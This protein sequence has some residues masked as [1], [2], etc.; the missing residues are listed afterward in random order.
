MRALA[1]CGCVILLAATMAA[2]SFTLYWSS[3]EQVNPDGSLSV[4]PTAEVSG[5]DD[6]SF[7]FNCTDSSNIATDRPALML[8]G[9]PWFTHW[10]VSGGWWIDF[11][12]T[13]PAVLISPGQQA[14]LSYGASVDAACWYD[15]PE[16]PPSFDSWYSLEFQNGTG[17]PCFI[18]VNC[19]EPLPPVE[20]G[21]PYTATATVF[22]E[23]VAQTVTLPSI[24]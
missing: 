19:P 20:Y 17:Y 13:A 16:Y 18:G 9:N 11:A 4:T 23:L 10:R 21:S 12:A 6:S 7:I 14:D 3:T 22:G 8:N 5:Y 15:S 24:S 1:I 2:Q